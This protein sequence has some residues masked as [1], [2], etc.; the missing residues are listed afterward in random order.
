MTEPSDFIR[1]MIGA[2]VAAG[3][4]DG[5]VC[6]RFPP[7]PNG[8]L[9]IGHAKSIHLNFGIAKQFG[10][11]CHLRMDDTNPTTEDPEYVA[12]IQR[13]VRWLGF[14]WGQNMFYASDYYE[15]LYE[16]AEG[17]IQKGRAYVCDLTEADMGEYRGK[18]GEPGK[19]SPYRN[20]SVE[21]N[22]DRFRRMRKGEFK[23]GSC[24]LRAKI[25][26]ASPN[27]KMRDPP[28]YRIKHA[29]HYRTGDAWCIYPLYDY[30]HCLSD[31]FEKITH[32]LCTME[33]ESARE[34]Y[35]WVVAATEV[36]HVPRQTEFA[37]LNL[38]YTVMSKRR[39]LELVEKKLVRGW[40][41]PRMPTIA[42][43]RRRGVTREA[44]AEF[45]SRI[46]VAKNLSIVDMA[47]LE[48]VIREDL[49]QRSPRVMA[50]LKPIEVLIENYPEGEVEQLDAPYWPHDVP[51]EG[52]RKVPFSRTIYVDRDDF[53][54]NP[55]KDFHRLSPGKRVR[56]RHAYVVTCKEVIKDANG[57]LARLVC[58]YDPATR[59]G[60]APAGEKVAGTIQW[61]SAA[62]ALDAEVRIYDRLCRVESPGDGGRDFLED[63]NPDSL[64]VVQAKVEPSLSSA[65]EGQHYQFERVGFFFVDPDTRPGAPVF[66]RTVAL[67]DGWAKLVGKSEPVKAEAKPR[68][69]KAAAPKGDAKELTPAAKALAEQHALSADEARVISSEPAL[70]ALFEGAL[71]AGSAAKP[72]ASLL[73]NDV[74]RELRARR[75]E[76]APFDGAALGELPP[77]VAS[78]TLST[79]LAQEVLAEM[80]VRGARPAEIVKE[81]GL[82]QVSD[83]GAVEAAVAQVLADNPDT[84]ARYK[85]GNA[86]VVGALVGMV[87]K[88]LQGRANPKVVNEILKKQLG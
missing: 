46:G 81:K 80:F 70:A 86:N 57:D 16:L 20:R 75:L 50:V 27:M 26:M 62:H 32:S 44:I 71:A 40:D 8:Y 24:T 87:I 64:S 68:E 30:A 88:S 43:L 6:T 79:K 23:E 55:P 28:L 35:D 34:L 36:P 7:E 1:D 56:L 12:A 63:L 67:K 49:N 33:F 76:K 3:L 69:A 18:V 4:H 52:S 73:A 22:L 42:G 59:G 77:L 82:S 29:H 65:A 15:R 54:E 66:N 83:A 13:D 48:H 19:E 2:D 45:C 85:A 11:V 38:S 10:G 72:I 51:K 31:S 84:V 58:T 21:E 78:G 14:E 61:V 47:L 74:V 53:L 60:S 5:R 25:D 9:H 37:R 17:L 41:D 39:L